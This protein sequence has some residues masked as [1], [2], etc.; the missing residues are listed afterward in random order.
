[1][2]ENKYLKRHPLN[3]FSLHDKIAPF[4]GRLDLEVTERCNNNCIHCYINLPSKGVDAI[5]KELK[6]EE[7]KEYL[8]EAAS[9][10]CLSLKI[11]GGEP[12]LRAD[13]E[14]IYVYA[15]AL[16]MKVHLFTNATLITPQMASLF[17]RIPPQNKIEITIYGMDRGSYEST[18]RT[19]GSYEAAWRGIRLLLKG[20]V[21]FILKGAFFP[22]KEKDVIAFESLAAEIPWM[23]NC[24][25][26]FLMNLDLRCRRDSV[27]KND[28]I[29]SLR[30]TPEN[31]L[32]FLIRK[33]DEFIKGMAEFCSK[34]LRISGD[35]LFTC[36]AGAGVSCI[37]SYGK[38]QLCLLLR[39]PA[40]VYTLATGSLRDAVVRFSA[41][42]R[43]YVA[44]DPEYLQKCAN[45][46]LKGLCEQC[47]GKSW[48]EYGTLDKPVEYLCGRAQLKARFLG[49]LEEDEKS[50]EVKDWEKRIEGIRGNWRGIARKMSH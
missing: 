24:P 19:A 1:M 23:E 40:T 26:A 10:G 15:R 32:N 6:T 4:I 31:E 25:P 49:L 48:I 38:Y 29:R 33:K 7:I 42:V 13:F 44:H 5:S 39:H 27:L 12:L 21:P 3:G 22:L 36:N 43:E 11:T 16:R 8:K 46:F 17:V 50:W 47:P 9:L 41:G 2:A 18:T 45:C 37:D 35:S 30:M 28:L 34:Y 14:E 20:N